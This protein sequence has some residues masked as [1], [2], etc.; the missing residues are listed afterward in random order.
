[1]SEE[2]ASSTTQGDTSHI[3][4]AGAVGETFRDFN[5]LQPT[6]V[7]ESV[8][9]VGL[10]SVKANSLHLA[11]GEAAFVCSVRSFYFTL[12]LFIFC[13]GSLKGSSPSGAYTIASPHHLVLVAYSISPLLTE[14]IW[15][16]HRLF[17]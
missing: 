17:A 8:S 12:A 13:C 7:N 1:M 3:H 11:G 16:G 15:L 4:R 14:L 2:Y 9:L 5:P 10:G 6:F